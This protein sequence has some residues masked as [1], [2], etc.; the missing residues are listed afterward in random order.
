MAKSLFLVACKLLSVRFI[1]LLA[2]NLS[3][4]HA[5]LRKAKDYEHEMACVFSEMNRSQLITTAV[6]KT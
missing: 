2:Y 4:R 6:D 5:K 1:A 3:I